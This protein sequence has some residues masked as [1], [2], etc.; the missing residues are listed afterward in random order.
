MKGSKPLHHQTVVFT[1]TP[2]SQD[3]FELV[4]EYGGVPVS[5]PLIQVEELI[6][7]TD[8][9]RLDACATYDWLIFTSQSAVAAFGEKLKR[10]D[11]S[12]DLIPSNVAAIGT[13]TAAALEEI[14]FSVQFIPT[15][16]SAD[17]FVKEF[18]PVENDLRRLLFLRGTIAGPTIS[19]ELP[20][21]VDE[22]T[23]YETKKVV[24]NAGQL[25]GLLQTEN[26]VSVLF[27]S[28]SAVQIFAEEVAPHTG[29]E[30]YTIGAIGHVT[31]RALIK[32]GAS[33][34][35]RPDIY[36]LKDLVDKLANRKDVTI[37]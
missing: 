11:F 30:G 13:R 12:V 28:P 24:E 8:Q 16:F 36:T 6:E 15:V 26:D 20:F 29:W 31:E 10:H 2:K 27:A 5:L 37:D 35:V 7:S 17:V 19:E 3:V 23:V 34:D 14:G 25:T 18:D 22:W 1:G 21:E 33:V 32:E 4:K 9:L